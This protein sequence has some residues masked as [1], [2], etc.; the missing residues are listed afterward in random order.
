MSAGA[1]ALISLLSTLFFIIIVSI[2]VYKFLNFFIKVLTGSSID[3]GEK[4]VKDSIIK[5][6]I[7]GF[8]RNIFLQ[9]RYLDYIKIENALYDFNFNELKQ[10]LTDEL[11]E[12]VE[13]RLSS[14][15]DKEK[16]YEINNYKYCDSII[17]DIFN[18]NDKLF[19]KIELI[20]EVNYKLINGD[21]NLNNNSTRKVL[22][23]VYLTF[24]CDKNSKWLL[25][26]K[27]SLKMNY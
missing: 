14:I 22:K 17:V 7:P 6:Y 3:A 9:K 11:Y 1:E 13:Q 2:I 4:G 8:N 15:H 25:S 16:K 23:H 26:E 24:L 5:K 18:E 12:H 10:L 21:S 20:Y 27:E 19:V